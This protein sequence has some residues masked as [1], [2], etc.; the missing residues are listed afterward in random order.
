MPDPN[1][2][3]L[4]KKDIDPNNFSDPNPPQDQKAPE[5]KQP[6]TPTDEKKEE[7]NP[8]EYTPRETQLF[9]RAKTAEEKLK[10]YRDK[11][12]DIEGNKPPV[13]Q[14]ESDPFSLAKT[15]ASLK[16][17]DAQS[18]DFASMIAKA[19]GIRP[20]DA[21]KTE[22]FKIFL[23]GKKLSDSKN[24]SIPHPNNSAPSDTVK[25]AQEIEKMTDAE[26]AAYEREYNAKNKGGGI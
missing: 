14:N 3:D 13:Q 15:V 24:N 16:D 11:F 25:S 26:F 21:V 1:A 9:S 12:G 4:G 5:E 18:L 19:K 10:L 23:E 6:V 8:K 17:Y 20:E 7:Q 2:I 22:E